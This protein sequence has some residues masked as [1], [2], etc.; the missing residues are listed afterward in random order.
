MVYGRGSLETATVRGTGTETR[1]R[2]GLGRCDG[3]ACDG[4]DDGDGMRTTIRRGEL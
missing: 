2:S 4:G 3:G 1:S